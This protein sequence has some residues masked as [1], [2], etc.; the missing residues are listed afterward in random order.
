[1]KMNKNM[2]KT[3]SDL[4]EEIKITSDYINFLNLKKTSRNF[5][6][7]NPIK[8]N[9][10]YISISKNVSTSNLDF[11][12]SNES[13]DFKEIKSTY[14]YIIN[15]ID[16]LMNKLNK[17]N[18]EDIN[19]IFIKIK[20]VINKLIPNKILNKRNI[21][22][23]SEI[24]RDKFEDRFYNYKNLKYTFDGSVMSSNEKENEINPLN[25]LNSFIN[26]TS[27]KFS[28]INNNTKK[29]KILEQKN[30]DLEDKLKV[31]KW[32]YLF[33]I[34]EQHKKIKKLE[35]ELN[36]KS[37]ENMT[38]NES[39]QIK[40]FPYA[41]KYDLLDK[42]SLRN[43]IQNNNINKKNNSNKR[44]REYFFE[45][46]SNLDKSEEDNNEIKNTKE[47]IECGK[48]VFNDK[49]LE[50]N[51]FLD[52]QGTYFI[53]HPKLSYVKGD[54]NMK[55]WKTNQLADSLPK[56]VLRHKFTSKSQKDHLIV[57]PSSLN[58]IMVNLEKLRIHNDFNRIENEFNDNFKKN[59]I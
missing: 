29:I 59:D 44:Y 33:C 39:R 19:L 1:M 54:L 15:K 42:Y 34:G 56:G 49:E 45:Q 38:E 28:K 50:G 13:K 32:K 11:N 2:R 47:I 31:E 23:L 36:Q 37:F 12:K 43:K 22:N 27:S 16:S 3:V 10:K 9:K 20:N 30:I 25:K 51:K 5:M 53:S 58:Q 8:E 57:F 4:Q 46:Y 35:K 14:K 18:Y 21:S 52:K 48:K 26:E 17:N 7:F 6:K 41:K 40:C 55:S 24:K